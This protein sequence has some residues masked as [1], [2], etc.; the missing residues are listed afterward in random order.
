M[1]AAPMI[2]SWIPDTASLSA[3]SCYSLETELHSA[4]PAFTPRTIRAIRALCD[5]RCVFCLRDLGVVGECHHV[6]D[7][8]D[9]RGARMVS[10][11]FVTAV[12]FIFEPFR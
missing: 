2:Y 6:V 11:S 10:C 5:D 9:S 1:S 7:S 8:S 4:M 12:P 3:S